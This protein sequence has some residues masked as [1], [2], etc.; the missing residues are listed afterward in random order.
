MQSLF[1]SA[2]TPQ[3]PSFLQTIQQTTS[4]FYPSNLSYLILLEL[5]HPG[6]TPSIS[7][8]GKVFLAA[9][10]VIQKESRPFSSTPST[11]QAT[12]LLPCQTSPSS[13][14][15]ISLLTDCKDTFHKSSASF[16]GFNISTL[17]IILLKEGSPPISA[18]ALTFEAST[19]AII[20]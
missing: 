8:S 16:P 20:L 13:K 12:Y 9:A 5:Y 7:A 6:M 11:S 18:N 19:L 4:L 10:A 17:A 15:S 1:S 3:P 14:S 2:S